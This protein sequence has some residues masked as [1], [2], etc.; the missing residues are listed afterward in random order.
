MV[1][2]TMSKKIEDYANDTSLGVGVSTSKDKKC[3][4]AYSVSTFLTNK[5]AHYQHGWCYEINYR[6]IGGIDIE[7]TLLKRNCKII[8]AIASRKAEVNIIGKIEPEDIVGCWN[9]FDEY[10]PNP[11]YLP[12]KNSELTINFSARLARLFP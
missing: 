11:N 8:A 10:I 9:K 3:A 6:G 7:E 2:Q 5:G 4:E 12:E 1:C